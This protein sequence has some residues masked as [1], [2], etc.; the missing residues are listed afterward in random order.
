LVQPSL[1]PLDIQREIVARIESERKI[2]EGNVVD[3]KNWTLPVG[4]EL[5]TR[6]EV[7]DGKKTKL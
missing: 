2:V 1:P 3:P 4:V 5:I 7:Y 6:N